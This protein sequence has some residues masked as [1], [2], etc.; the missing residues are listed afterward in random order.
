FKARLA[1]Y[2]LAPSYGPRHIGSGPGYVTKD[3]I[4]KVE[5]Y[6]GQFR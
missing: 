6:A 3:N 5:K 4:G 2:G 1:E